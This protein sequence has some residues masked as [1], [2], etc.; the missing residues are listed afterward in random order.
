MSQNLIL[1]SVDVVAGYGDAQILNGISIEVRRGKIVT[2]IGPN[3]SGKSTFLKT[4]VGLVKHRSG[5][6]AITAR[7][8]E[9]LDVTN[10][11][12]Y[13]LAV[14]GVSY[15][16]QM[17][18]IFTDMSVQ[19]NLQMGAIPIR[20][21]V[22]KQKQRIEYVIE[23]FPVLA[24]R[25]S[26]RAGYLSGGQRQMLAIARAL[27]ADP[28]LIVLDEPS[29]GIQP[30]LVDSIFEKIKEL[31]NQ[32]LSILL[33]EQKARQALEFSDYAYALEMGE[34][35]IE[36]TGEQLASD[37]NVIRLYLGGSGAMSTRS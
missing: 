23:Q 13:E 27:V 18:N 35:R 17:A 3:G 30:D 32:G 37:P 20:A 36:G 34:N 31:S 5:R 7:N 25:L 15:V 16:P 14:L 10:T 4:L 19:E 33:V 24:Q 26:S 6:T 9:E 2:I 28:Q 29:A 12:P 1:R 21:E 11:R 8:G 22:G